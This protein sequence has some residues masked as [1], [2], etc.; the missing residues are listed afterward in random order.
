L[1]NCLE[2]RTKD[3]P[4]DDYGVLIGLIR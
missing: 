2:M 3:A 4:Y 1:N